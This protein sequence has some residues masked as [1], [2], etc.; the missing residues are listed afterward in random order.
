MTALLKQTLEQYRQT[1]EILI[2]DNIGLLGDPSRLRDACE[3][4]LLNGGKRFRPAL[5]MMVGAAVNE[6]CDLSFAAL[7]IEYFHTASLIADDLPS[8]DN[9][10]ERRN[11]PSLHIAFDEATALM[12]SYALISAGYGC[13]ARNAQI[14]AEA[15]LPFSNRAHQLCTLAV[16]NVS[17]NTG[18]FGATGGQFLD[19]NPPDLQLETLRDIA[20]KKTAS[21]FEISFVLGWLYAGGDLAKISL[22]KAA[23][24][25][26]GMAFQI[27]DDLGDMD[28]DARNGRTV[29]IASVVGQKRAEELFKQE[30]SQYL[31]LLDEL[32]IASPELVALAYFA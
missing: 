23:A 7:A 21:L 10:D 12:A 2:A 9:D 24:Y 14:L 13:L 22:V 26:F 6:A 25:H 18:L 28:Q 8:M 32:N 29:N 11:K 1:V 4:A 20:C 31:E 3:Y 19:I 27:G 5:V 15:N 30:I 17:F 16:E